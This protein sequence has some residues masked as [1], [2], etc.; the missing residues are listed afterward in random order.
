[1][2]C[3]VCDARVVKSILD[4]GVQPWGNHFLKKDER[5]HEPRY[6]LHLMYCQECTTAQLNHTVAKEVMF[7]DHTYLSGTTQS[8][9]SHFKEVAECV[10]QA[11]YAQQKQKS[12]LDIGS[13]DG[14]QLEHFK[15]LGYEILGVESSKTTAEI[16]VAKGIPTVHAF[17][18]QTLVH[19]LRRQFDLIHASGVFFHLEELHSVT[20]GIR[21]AL[22]PSGI[23]VVQF[24]Y[25]QSLIDKLAFDQI[26]HEH[27]LYYNLKTIEILLNRHGLTVFDAY[28][29]SI[30]GG[31]MIAYV[32]HVGTRPQTERL[33]HLLQKEHT[34]V[35]LLN[36]YE[37]FAKQVVHL[38]AQNLEY[39]KALRAQGKRIFG[40]GAPVKGNTLL[41][42]FGIG[43]DL[44]E[45]L[46]EKNPLRKGLFAPGSHIPI[47]LESEITQHPDVY[48]VLAWNFKHEILKNNQPLL[49]QGIEFF[50]PVDPDEVRLIS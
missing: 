6:P 43:P 28:S 38:K 13:N 50:F 42:Y 21:E 41:N 34:G 12:V 14:T 2:I 44:I 49:N 24:I 19:T 33:C 29:S 37:A 36:R 17:F 48:Y 8:L 26:Y 46:V 10:D 1:M 5:G 32:C 35:P 22:K 16:A 11:F 9:S 25:M 27:L 30:H 45:V 3:R 7:S 39:L 4:L 20:Q 15:N 18:N 23:F 47:V 31:S 40:M